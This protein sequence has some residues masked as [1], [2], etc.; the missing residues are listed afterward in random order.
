MKKHTNKRLIIGIIFIC[1]VAAGAYVIKN[2]IGG[3]GIP[4]SETPDG[5]SDQTNQNPTKDPLI[6]KLSIPK[7]FAMQI[8][9][10]NIKGARVITFDSK[11]R[12]LVSQTSEGKIVSLEDTNKDGTAETIKTLV[13]GLSKPHGLAMDCADTCTLYV[14]ERSRLSSYDYD[15]VTSTVSN[16]KKLLTLSSTATDNHSTRTLQFL[17]GTD[18]KTLLI[19]VG[20][21]CNV[22]IESDTM[23]GRIMAYDIPTA[24][25]SEY[26]RGLRNAVFMTVSPGGK[27]FASEMG[28]DSLGDD[29]PPDEINIIEPTK[30][31]G[32][33]NCYGK[34]IHDSDFDKKT[35]IRNPCSEPFETPAF[36][37]L[38]AH[39]APLGIAFVPDTWKDYA[40]NMLIAFHG[41]WNRTEPTGYKIARIIFDASG[42]YVK[43][44][45]FI[46]GWLT[47][48]GSKLGRP[49]AIAFG[50]D[51]AAYI[52]DD[53]NGDIY[54][55]FPLK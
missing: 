17:P 11:D 47:K 25:V 41:S 1:I 3:I 6:A 34:N 14:A 44:E 27:V 19:S 24:K 31:Y 55:L 5:I 37:D 16:S 54:R 21:S 36:I 28:R 33:P 49:V 23:R 8:F 46:T 12:M 45:D 53:N 22:C 13:T 2:K 38:P 18:N 4:P 26:A 35:Y 32:W 10:K 29:I 42:N 20:S 48:D 9:A 39:S 7:D 50:K 30:N 52:S 40:G 15:P 51:N 43:T